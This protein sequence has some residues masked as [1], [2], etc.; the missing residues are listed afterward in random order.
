M[1]GDERFQELVKLTHLGNVPI[2]GASPIKEV[3]SLPLKSIRCRL[4]LGGLV[5]TLSLK[6]PRS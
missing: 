5:K 2:H 6:A 1:L 3:Q 4:R